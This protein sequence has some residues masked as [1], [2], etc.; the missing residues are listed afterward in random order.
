MEDI[1]LMF[2]DL[3]NNKVA[4]GNIPLKL[5]K[6]CDFTYEKLTDNI[7]SSIITG[8]F[9]DSLKRANLGQI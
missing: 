4:G 8:L 9:C 1:R 2:K 5:L 6:E 7:N 3:M